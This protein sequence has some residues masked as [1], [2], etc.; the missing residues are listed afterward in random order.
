MSLAL[1]TI[2]NDTDEILEIC[3]EIDSALVSDGTLRTWYFSTNTRETGSSETPANTTFLPYIKPGG[4]LGPLSQSLTADVQLSGLLQASYGTLTLLQSNPDEDNLSEMHDYVFAGY[5]CRIKIGRQSNAYAA[6]ETYR[7]VEIHVD[8]T[9]ELVSSGLQAVFL[10]QSPLDRMV[11]ESL[12]SKKYVG[13]PHCVKALT[14]TFTY[15]IPS[16]AAY[17]AKSFTA[18]IRFRPQS[19]FGGTGASVGFYARR[20]SSAT[21]RQFQ[22]SQFHHTR[23]TNP[24][25]VQIDLSIAGVSKTI[26][27]SSAAILDGLWHTLVLGIQDKTYGYVVLDREIVSE[28]DSTILTASVDIPSQP[29]TGGTMQ[30][31]SICD[32][33]FYSHFIPPDQAITLSDT[34]AVG[35]EIGTVSMV[36]FDDNSGTAANDYSA[37]A[38]DAAF[39]GVLNT[40]YQWTF[41]D[42]GEPELSGRPYPILAGNVLNAPATLIDTNRHRVRGNIDAVDWHT[43][44]S[45][46]TLTVRSQGTVLTGGGTDYTAPTDGGDGVFS[47]TTGEAEPIT[48]DL[49]NNGTSEQSVYPSNV[50]KNLLTH[51]TRLTAGQIRNVDPLTILCPWPSGYWTDQETT[52]AQAL[53]S[54]LGESGLHYYEKEDGALW[55]D[56]LLPPVGYGPY[57]EPCLDLRGRLNAEINLGDRG[58]I[59]S[60]ASCTICGWVKINLADQTAFNFGAEPNSGTFYVLAKP[61]LT[62]NFAVYFQATGPNAGKF[63][64]KIGGVTL[65]T[66]TG[67]IKPYTWYFFACVF[68]NTANTS[69]IYLGEKDNTLIEVASGANTGTPVPNSSDL[70]AGGQGYP[71]MSVQH[72]HIWSVTKTS[73]DLSTLMATPPV[74]NEANLLVYAPL[75]EGGSPIIELVSGGSITLSASETDGVPQWCPKMLVNLEDTPTVKLADFH[76]TKPRYDITVK[77]AKNRF[78]M[79][80]SDIDSGVS[81]NNRLALTREGLEQSF[82]S[83]VIRDR[84]KGSLRA[85][86]DSPITDQ[87]SAQRLLRVVTRRFDMNVGFIGTLTFP[88]GLNISRLACG[89]TIGDEIGLVGGI[90]RPVNTA[91]SFRVIATSPDPL[92][93]KTTLGILSL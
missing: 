16:N 51:R 14:N 22:I 17:D 28:V 34:R 52:A 67:V 76:R 70:R 89:L 82:Y 20:F 80:N 5:Q 10:L 4:T 75:N 85:V 66:S 33:R 83:P 86:F 18:M 65:G 57:N 59:T 1:D 13:I 68:D 84:F 2:L 8:P 42:L 9:I 79:N 21:N 78:K 54:I 3:V 46:T 40:D 24:G 90:P 15:S 37:T 74:G 88:P 30:N 50:A 56:M 53:K 92:Q 58:D 60:G 41:T 35:D 23:A 93:L 27:L 29:I 12:I 61:N 6:F 47:F 31:G 91:K 19:D 73:S 39:S 55:L 77:Y 69:K 32:F 63:F 45:N 81:A 44:T 71:W 26:W 64:F 11:N 62:G 38:N 87:E 49:L 25:K 43:S 7:T 72:V 48:F 36:R